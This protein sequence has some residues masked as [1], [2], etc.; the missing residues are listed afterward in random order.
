MI[1]T[2]RNLPPP[3][4]VIWSHHLPLLIQEPVRA[5]GPGVVPV[6]RVVVH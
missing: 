2:Q 4:G 1:Q 3:V 5:E 6:L